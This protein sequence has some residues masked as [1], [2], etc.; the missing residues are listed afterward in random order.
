MVSSGPIDEAQQNRFSTSPILQFPLCQAKIISAAI[1]PPL[2]AKWNEKKKIVNFRY[3]HG[4]CAPLCLRVCSMNFHYWCS[5]C[6]LLCLKT[7]D[8]AADYIYIALRLLAVSRSYCSTYF[9][10]TCLL[11]GSIDWKWKHGKY[12]IFFGA[13]GSIFYLFVHYL[14]VARRIKPATQQCIPGAY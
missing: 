11:I 14:G 3:C 8:S 6:A 7:Q 10:R 13:P 4:K 2:T 9:S 1:F 12:E 5:K